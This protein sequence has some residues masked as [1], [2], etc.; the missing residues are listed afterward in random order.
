[1]IPL[2]NDT[3]SSLLKDFQESNTALKHVLWLWPLLRWQQE[4]ALL[5]HHFV[6]CRNFPT[7]LLTSLC[8]N[9]VAGLTLSYCRN[10]ILLCN[11]PPSHT[12]SIQCYFKAL[13][14]ALGACL[15]W[16]ITVSQIIQRKIMERENH[17]RHYFSFSYFSFLLLLVCFGLFCFLWI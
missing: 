15:L 7:S 1:M 16:S 6:S 14:K 11:L 8:V 17:R 4:M 12:W 2:R 3:F 10:K 13:S 5:H 9:S